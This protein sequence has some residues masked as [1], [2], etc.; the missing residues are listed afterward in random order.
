MKVILNK[1][2]N[3]L[4]EEGDIKEVAKGYARNFLFPRGIALP[5]TEK[6]VKLF[7]ARRGEI[8]ARK[9]AK[10][11]DASGIKARL[12]ELELV[13][14]MPAGANGRLYGAVTSQT[15]MEELARQGFP[16]E[17][18]RIELPGN[19]FKSV[20]KYKVA[21]KLYESASAE[22]SVTVQAQIIKTEA[23]EQPARKG[24]RHQAAA[25]GAADGSAAAENVSPEAPAPDNGAEPA[26]ANPA[27]ESAPPAEAAPEQN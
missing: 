23:R 25:E 7:E 2:L 3:P 27:G 19:T 6:T 26:Q 24:R 21:V 1:D 18:K 17:R 9:A 22:V 11:Q 4:G 15:V 20:G 8:E 10:R 13:I 14:S 5:Y 12:E 16:M